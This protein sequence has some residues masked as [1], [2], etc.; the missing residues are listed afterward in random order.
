MQ[1]DPKPFKRRE[2]TD[3]SYYYMGSLLTFLAES[4]DTGGTFSLFEI[5]M[6]PGNEPPPHI[7][8][9]ED[10]LY[11]V[12]EGEATAY[13]GEEEFHL[14]SGDSLFLPRKKPHGFIVR[15]DR[16]RM[17]FLTQPG[18]AEGYFKAMMGSR[19]TVLD[20]PKEVPTYSTTD[21]QEAIAVGTEYGLEFLGPEQVMKTLPGF[22]KAHNQRQHA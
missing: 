7:H 17:L 22:Y 11:Y 4:K 8:H 13:I 16:F 12:L 10:E 9:G 1:N 20:L 18:G 21:V 15:T 14:A 19:A 2:S 6:K 3:A 5:L